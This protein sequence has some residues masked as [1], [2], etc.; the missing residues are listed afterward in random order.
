M[1]DLCQ[2]CLKH[3]ATVFPISTLINFFFSILFS[4]EEN[5]YATIM[6]EEKAPESADEVGGIM[7]AAVFETT[8]PL[9]LNY[10]SNSFPL[11]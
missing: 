6:R 2:Q 9:L 7:A 10:P 3:P 11:L 1:E 4:H 5:I 8:F